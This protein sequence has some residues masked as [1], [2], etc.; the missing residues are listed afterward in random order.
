MPDP[1]KRWHDNVPGAW[2]VDEQCIDCDLCNE[3]APATFKGNETEGHSLV[4]KQPDTEEELAAAKE[5]MTSCPVDAIGN[6]G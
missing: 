1:V 3:I 4:F 5:A 6:D 2:Y